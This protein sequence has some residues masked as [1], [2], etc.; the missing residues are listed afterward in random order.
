VRDLVE[1]FWQHWRVAHVA[2][3]E[4]CSSDP[5][6]FLIDPDEDLAPNTA[7]RAAVPAGVPLPFALDLDAGAIDQKI[8]R[9]LRTTVGELTFKVFW[10]RLRVLKSGT[11]QS[12]PINRSRHSTKPVVCLC[13]MPNRTFIVRQVWMAVS[14]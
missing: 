5:Q 9:P 1:Q 2:G 10:R 6:C 8:E 7:L 12:S 13:A 4:L 3:G 11:A 14:L